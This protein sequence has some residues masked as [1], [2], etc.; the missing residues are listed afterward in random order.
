M[1][2]G[3]IQLLDVH[4]ALE[5]ER[6][7]FGDCHPLKAKVSLVK[8][9]D[10]KTKIDFD[11]CLNETDGI[12]GSKIINNFKKE[13]PELKYLVIVL[14]VLLS[15]HNLN[16]TYE[17]GINSFG[18]ILLVISYLQQHKNM[19]VQTSEE[20]KEKSLLSDHLINF[21]KLYGID[22]NYKKLG[23][24]V[25]KD[26]FYYKRDDK[27][28]DNGSHARSFLSLE[29]PMNNDLNVAT[30]AHQYHVIKNLF[31]KCYEGIVAQRKQT[32]I[33]ILNMI[34]PTKKDYT[35]G[36]YDF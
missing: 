28:F 34:L 29:N 6:D 22:F 35:T 15:V 13:F 21:F 7:R 3:R 23:I 9:F 18:L 19:K 24:S 25:R 10:Q 4:S 5:E 16:K 26:G 33:S 12:R 1:V 20:A 36:K 2:N 11:I 32:D 17:G 31:R 30:A 14:K 8:G 27:G